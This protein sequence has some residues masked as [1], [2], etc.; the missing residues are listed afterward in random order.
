MVDMSGQILNQDND[1]IPDIFCWTKMG[2]EAGQGLND[3]LHRKELERAA[4]NGSFAWGIGNSLGNSA[5]FARQQSPTGEV[6]VLFT[7]MKSAPIVT[8]TSPSQLFLW[9]Y[10]LSA[11]G[12]IKTLPEHMLITSRGQESK[13]SHYALLCHSSEEISAKDLGGFHSSSVRNL[14]SMNPVG[15]SQVTSIVRYQTL[16]IEE[17]PYRVSFKAKFHGEGFVKLIE[18]VL[19]DEVLTMMYQDAC[20]SDSPSEWNEA[21]SKLKRYVLQKQGLPN[22]Q[23]D[24]FDD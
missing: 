5:N 9:L 2:A 15:A 8:D 18:P 10:Y 11:S 23:E 6:D 24:M 4:G 7:P 1:V 3:I 12:K 21:V 16:D 13:R 14:V 17:K 22:F 20:A 19:M